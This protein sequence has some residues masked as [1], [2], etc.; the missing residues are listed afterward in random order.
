MSC[1]PEPA[2]QSCDTV[3][4]IPF[5]DSCLF[6]TTWMSNTKFYTDIIKVC[7]LPPPNRKGWTYVRTYSVQTIFSEA[8][9]LGSI[10]YH[11]SLP[12]VLHY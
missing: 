9:F 5:F 8:K 6:I 10:D 7:H 4:Q 11:I 12:T 1:I 2:V 3:Q